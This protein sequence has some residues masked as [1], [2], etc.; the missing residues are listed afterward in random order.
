M[1][2]IGYEFPVQLIRNLD[3]MNPDSF[4]HDLMVAAEKLSGNI[5]EHAIKKNEAAALTI[6]TGAFGTPHLAKVAANPAFGSPGSYTPPT[7]STANNGWS[8]PNHGNWEQVDG[9]TLTFNTSGCMLWI[10]SCLQAIWELLEWGGSTDPYASAVYQIA[11]RLD[12]TILD[13]TISGQSDPLHQPPFA[14]KY[15]PQKSANSALPGPATPKAGVVSSIGEPCSPDRCIATSLFQLSAG[16]HT[17]DVV[18]RRGSRTGTNIAFSLLDVVWIFDRMLFALEVPTITYGTSTAYEY[19]ITPI[20]SND[21]I[22]TATLNTPL[23]AM[24]TQYND[25]ENS[26]LARGALNHNHGY[27]SVLFSTQEYIEPATAQA[28]SSTYPGYSSVTIDATGV[29]NGWYLLNDGAGNTLR[30][31]ETTPAGFAVNDKNCMLLVLANVQYRNMARGVQDNTA[32][33]ILYSIG[34]VVTK[35]PASTFFYNR[36]WRVTGTNLQDTLNEAWISI[37]GCIDFTSVAPTDDIEWIGV[38][39]SVL[40]TD[41]TAVQALSYQRGSMQVIFFRP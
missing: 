37:A 21:T 32:F 29:G 6:G 24:K 19:E 14:F 16:S 9:L 33:T 11:L 5:N 41:N 26:N 38:Y 2:G 12:G 7:F 20:E 35:I 10:V 23:N 27:S 28:T 13:W 3:Q 30:T 17:I 25:I 39:A 4:N 18:A 40:A 22:T 34:G 36:A 1:N 31:D 8:I 15:E